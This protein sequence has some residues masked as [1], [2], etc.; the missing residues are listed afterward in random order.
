[1]LRYN[2]VYQL[3]RPLKRQI[4]SL[5]QWMERPSMGHVYL[6][7]SDRDTWKKPNQDDMMTLEP[8][9]DEDGLTSNLT[10]ALI[11]Y[12]NTIFGRHIH[13]RPIDLIALS[14]LKT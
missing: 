12:Y 9:S 1:M 7:G 2:K 11:G 10:L 14:N 13:V 5:N 3:K 6:E 4:Q 8:A